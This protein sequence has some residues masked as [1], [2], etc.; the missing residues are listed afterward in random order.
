MHF[1]DLLKNSV[2]IGASVDLERVY[3]ECKII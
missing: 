1:G 2:W 3:E